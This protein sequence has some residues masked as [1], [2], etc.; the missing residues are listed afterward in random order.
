MINDE[1]INS[2]NAKNGKYFFTLKYNYNLYFAPIEMSESQARAVIDLD[3]SDYN[4]WT[5]LKTDA[6]KICIKN[7]LSAKYEDTH[8]HEYFNSH[9]VR[10][11][12]I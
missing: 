4:T 2:S 1:N 3:E 6:G 11:P 12:S 8:K 10:N 9:L 5:K 7:N